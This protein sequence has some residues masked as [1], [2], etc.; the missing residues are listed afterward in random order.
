[1]AEEFTRADIGFF[2]AR[3]RLRIWHRPLLIDTAIAATEVTGVGRW[4]L[5]RLEAASTLDVALAVLNGTACQGVRAT[6]PMVGRAP[7]TVSKQLAALR[8]AGLVDDLEPV[9][10]DLFEAVVDVWRPHRIPVADLPRPGGG[11]INERLRVGFDDLAAPGWVL[12]DT[13]EGAAW[14]A[15][16]VMSSD[17]PPDFYVPDP[18]VV[19]LARSLFGTADYGSHACTVAVAPSPYVC[20]R[21][22]DRTLSDFPAPDPVIAAWTSQLTRH[23]VARCSISGAVTFLR[24]YPVSGEIQLVAPADSVIARSIRALDRFPTDEPWV[25]VGGIAVFIRL[26]SV[27]RPTADADTVARSQAQLLDR[28]VSED[29]TILVANGDVSIA[30]DGVGVEIDVMDLADEPLPPDAER[31]AFALARGL[32]LITATKHTVSVR[33]RTSE[34]TA[35][36]TLPIATIPALVALKTVSMIRRPHSHHP[37]KVGSDIH[38]L[39]R[40]VDAV[41]AEFKSHAPP[42][43]VWTE[44]SRSS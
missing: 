43:W 26:G 36:A 21:R 10:P 29:P 9:V 41:G 37:E 31:R 28:L 17:S 14:G 25:L 33:D 19:A 13:G 6:A 27:T 22:Y 35:E 4:S 30:V 24:R 12:A 15:P 5:V 23:A 32:A 7:G 42:R 1:M 8:A 38:D 34:A 11:R 44:T 20:R 39:V 16:I 18:G 3:G 2:D 40:L